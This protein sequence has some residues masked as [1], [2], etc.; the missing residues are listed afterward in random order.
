MTLLLLGALAATLLF[1]GRPLLA[2]LLPGLAYLALW[3]LDLRRWDLPLDA[4]FFAAA[5]AFGAVT[6]VLGTPALRRRLI[7]KHL[8]AWVHKR[9]PELD[10]AERAL[11]DEACNESIDPT[12]SVEPRFER[13]LVG[14]RPQWQELLDFYI[15][16][17][18]DHERALLRGPVERLCADAHDWSTYCAGDLSN[19][20]WSQVASN[21]LLGLRVPREFGGHEL[22]AAASGAVIARIAS[23]SPALGWTLAQSL[24]FVDLLTRFGTPAQQ[25]YHLPRL[26]RG[27]EIPCTLA[28][29]ASSG[30]SGSATVVRGVFS[31]RQ[32]LGVRLEWEGRSGA[33]SPLATVLAVNVPLYDPEQLLGAATERGNTWFLVPTQLSGIEHRERYE[34]VLRGYAEGPVHA[35]GVFVPLDYVV[36]GAVQIGSGERIWNETN[37]L[38]EAVGMPAFVSGSAQL[39]LRTIRSEHVLRHVGDGEPL[40]SEPLARAAGRTYALRATR[41]L[42]AGT[43]D[44][45]TSVAGLGALLEERALFAWKNV[46]D[47]ALEIDAVAGARRGPSNPLAGY[48]DAL[49]LGAGRSGKVRSQRLRAGYRRAVL[50]HH[51][52]VS[53]LLAAVETDDLPAFDRAVVRSLGLVA[54]NATRA[55]LLAVFRGRLVLPPIDGELGRCFGQFSR[56]AAATTLVGDAQRWTASGDRA[57]DSA[58]EARLAQSVGWLYVGSAD[59]KAFHDAGQP[60]L[61]RSVARWAAEEA[62]YQSQEALRGVLDNLRPR[63]I[64][65]LLRAVLFPPGTRL[66]PPTDGLA[67]RT[68]RELIETDPVRSRLSEDLFEPS[69]AEPGLGRLESAAKQQAEA[70]HIEQLLV[71]AAEAGRISWEPEATLLERAVESGVL[72]ARQRTAYEAARSARESVLSD[73]AFPPDDLAQAG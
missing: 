15:H 35:R 34:S 14:G 66:R 30:A 23:R 26:A 45:G 13:R 18:D 50:A 55:F 43:V 6:L 8:A 70:R 32:T 60:A 61:Q 28:P 5:A 67:R 4:P 33:L 73:D 59:L 3:A 17:P 69:P 44:S 46:V 42:L 57:A 49:P 22:S 2:W 38:V 27:E 58:L 36:G 1:V 9:L 68:A 64:A 10:A 63:P 71:G 48:R 12:G 19:R 39:G 62:L 21:A 72:H 11:F 41:R 31:G 37:S 54:T 40:W 51:P 47:G 24:P 7:T 29:E 16:E 25:A 52:A 20:V 65:W 53:Q 56:L